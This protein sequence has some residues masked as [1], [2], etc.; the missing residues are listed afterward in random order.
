MLLL[1]RGEIC[2]RQ[3]K[4]RRLCRKKSSGELESGLIFSF[5]AHVLPASSQDRINPRPIKG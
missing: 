4:N 5:Q 3:M 1:T 2:G